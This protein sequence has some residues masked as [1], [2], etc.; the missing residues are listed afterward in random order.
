V[1][2]NGGTQRCRASSGEVQVCRAVPTTDIGHESGQRWYSLQYTDLQW[3]RRGRECQ[4]CA[5]TRL[6]SE[7]RE[8]SWRGLIEVRDALGDLKK[9]AERYVEASQD[10][11]DALDELT[12]SLEVLRAL[13]LHQQQ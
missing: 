8:D 11:S 4:E 3:F 5:D 7:I 9:D 12:E 2:I 10:V 13:R 6:S 1:V